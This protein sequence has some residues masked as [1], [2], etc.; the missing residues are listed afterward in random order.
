MTKDRLL[1]HSVIVLFFSN[2]KKQTARKQKKDLGDYFAVAL[3]GNV[4]CL[5]TGKLQSNLPRM[6]L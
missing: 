6:T 4:V 3:A 2:N 1:P 5:F